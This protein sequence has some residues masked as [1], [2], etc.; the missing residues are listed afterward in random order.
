MSLNCVAQTVLSVDSK[1]M[2]EYWDA[3]TFAMPKERVQFAFKSE[4]DLYDLAKARTV[5]CSIAVSPNGQL[6]AT[7]SRDKQVR[8]FD[9]ATGKLTRKYDESVAVYASGSSFSTGLDDLELG[10]RQ[11][12][13]REIESNMDALKQWNVLFDESSSFLLF[14]TLRG[15]KIVSLATN[16]LVRVIGGGEKSERF[17]SLALYTGVPAVDQQFLLARNQPSS[18]AAAA[19]AGASQQQRTSEEILADLNLP[20]P[21]LFATSFK[22]RRFYCLSTR[23]PDESEENRD[24]LNEL[25]TEE[26]RNQLMASSA[27]QQ[28]ALPTEAVL[29]TTLGDV[30]IKLFAADC[31]RTVENFTTHVRN[32]YFDNLIFHRVIKGF[33][34]Q[35]GDPLG[36]GT[37]GESIW[38]GE[39]EDEFVR[40]LRH[41]R[42]FTVSMANAGPNTNGSQVK[43][44][45]QCC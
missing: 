2:I 27:M 3:L 43:L 16:A 24:K 1:G 5:P 11:A 4:T 15:I 6:F 28:E 25:P 21:T 8:V 7:L 42:P 14:A 45:Y 22:R 41:D 32:G 12:V 20:D 39:F 35:T 19:G 9:F 44:F 30:V 33:M 13:E 26:E 37:G 36:D 10:K 31:P 17:L 40:T 18:A 23:E 34:V 38:G 29:H